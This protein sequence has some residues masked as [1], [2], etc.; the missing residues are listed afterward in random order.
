MSKS[1]KITHKKHL[2]YLYVLAVALMSVIFGINLGAMV[3][4]KVRL[5]NVFMLEIY[6]IDSIFN[7]FLIGALVGVFLGGRLAYDTGR[8]Q[9]IIGSFVVGIF[10]NCASILAPTFSTLFIAEFSVGAAFGAYMLSTLCYIGEISPSKYRATCSTLMGLFLTFGVL[11]S[12]ILKDVI[13]NWPLIVSS[14]F[15]ILGLINAALVYFLLPESPRWLALTDHSNKALSVLIR[16]RS[17]SSE[18]A[19]ELAAINESVLGEDRGIVLFFRNSVYRSLIW[20]MLFVVI[21]AHIGGMAIL[22]YE[23]MELTRIYNASI[24][25]TNYF[26][27]NEINFTLLLLAIIVAFIG[28]LVTTIFIDKIGRV[29]LLLGSSL[30]NIFAVTCLFLLNLKLFWK[31]DPIVMSS[32]LALFVF[33]SVIF[34][35]TFLFA[36]LPELL[37][38]KGR[39]LGLCIILMTNIA[40]LMLGIYFFEDGLHRF[41]VLSV[42]SLFVF[43]SVALYILIYRT[44]PE[45]KGRLLES[46]ENA[47]F[48]A[49]SLKVL[50]YK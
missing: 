8:V 33:S 4:S 10:G 47:I 25:K 50:K 36:V 38:A 30:V 1:N 46:M 16:I 17:S 45:T 19:R 28:N 24:G 20:L 42:L 32:L 12:I 43:A 2:V 26:G 5:I 15:V 13:P 37:P 27:A 49:R 14:I 23:S 41:G 21:I 48:N 40:L 31:I 34:A 6:N 9:V 35:N 22:P 7:T 11:I 18:A 39:E 44:L 3:S 29:K